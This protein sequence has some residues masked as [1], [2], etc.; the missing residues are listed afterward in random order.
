MG[1]SRKRK[2]HFY[3]TIARF[4]IIRKY[5]KVAKQN[6][7]K[8]ENVRREKDEE[9][10]LEEGILDETENRRPK[11]SSHESSCN[12]SSQDGFRTKIDNLL[13]NKKEDSICD[14]LGDDD[15]RV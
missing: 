11:S 10:R 6:Q 7:Q 12:R 3:S 14:D 9:D 1:L 5:Q 2:Q 15:R 4:L 13:M 8:I